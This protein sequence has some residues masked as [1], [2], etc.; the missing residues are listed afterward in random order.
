MKVIVREN[1][2]QISLRSF[3]TLLQ[4][5]WSTSY[6]CRNILNDIFGV[7]KTLFK[8]FFFHHKHYG[9]KNQI[10]RP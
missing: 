6:S 5:G 1:I 8:F 2:F 3:M 9:I 7:V 4:G 10:I